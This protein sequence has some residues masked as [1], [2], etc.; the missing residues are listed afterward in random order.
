M[1]REK[2]PRRKSTPKPDSS[3]RQRAAGAQPPPKAWTFLIYL[4]GDNHLETYLDSDFAEICRVGSLP[5]IHVVVQHDRPDGARRYLLPEGPV[6]QPQADANLGRVNTGDPAEAVKFLLW[7]IKQAPS[8]HVA[9]IFNGPGIN[10]NYLAQNLARQDGTETES[11]LAARVTKQL[12]S[13]CHDKTSSD[14]LEAHELRTILEQ[15]TEAEAMNR[16]TIDFIGLDMGA[17]AFV[18][19]A[20]QMEGLAQ[21]LVASQRFVPDNGWPY[22]QIL[23]RWQERLTQKSATAQDLGR[24]IVE[25]VADYYQGDKKYSPDDVRLAAVNLTALEAA[26]RALDT[27]ALALMQSLGDWHVLDA[28]RQAAQPL[29]W[30]KAELSE[31]QTAQATQLAEFLPAV[32]MFELL[33]HVHQALTEKSRSAPEIFGQRERARHLADLAEKALKVLKQGTRSGNRLLLHVR[34]TPDRG[35]SILLP[36]M[37][38]PEQID[39][40]TGPTFDLAGS[41][42]LDLNFS[43][44]VHWAA[45]V[46]AFQLIVEKPHVLWRLISSMLAD[47]SGP[48]RD[49][50]MQRLLSPDS[51]VEGL[52]RQF[53]SLG[54]DRALTLSLDPRDAEPGTERRTYRLRLESTVAGAIV[55]Q[56]ES[57]VYEPSI[58]TALRGLEQ[59][60]NS[61]DDNP[62]VLRDLMAFGRTLGEDLIQDLA[63]RL[64]AERKTA[65]EGAIEVT[66]H[67]RLQIPGELM[68]YPWELMYDRSGMLCERYAMGRQV[69]MATPMA[70]RVMRRRPGP[71]EVLIIGDPEF[72]PEFLEQFEKERRWR[73]PQLRGAEQEARV[74]VE[75]FERLGEELAGLPPLRITRL[76]G[77]TLT[78][79]EFRQRLREGTYD[80]I[81]YAGHACF[82]EKDPEASAWLLSDGLLRAR[83]IRNTLA[84]T[85]SPPWLVFANAC[86]AGMEAGAAASRYQGDVFG[87]ATAFINQGVAA[88]IAPLWLVNDEVAMQMAIDFYRALLLDRLSLGEA[89]RQARVLA[90]QEWASPPRAVASW[91]SLVLYG[92]P[93]PRLL[94][95]LWTPHAERGEKQKREAEKHE[96]RVAPRRRARRLPR[97]TVEQTLR[98]VSGP[99]MQPVSPEP[100]RGEAPV[101][102][103]STELKLVE[104]NGLRYWATV[105]EQGQLKP[106]S[107]LSESL[108]NEKV[109]GMLGAP[110]GV[111]DYAKVVGRWVVGKITGS[112]PESLLLRLVQQYDRETVATEQLL[113]IS[114]D[115]QLT[116][117]PP[118]PAPWDWLTGP[119]DRVLLILHGTFSKT[120][121]P[122]VGLGQEF[123]EWAYKH[124]RGAIGF[125]HWT[126]SKTPEDNAQMLWNRLDPRLRSGHRLDIITHSRGGLVARAFV[127]LLGHGAAVRRVV[128]VGTPNAGTNLANPENWGRVADWLVNLVPADP[129]G[130]YGRLSG[131]LAR[132]LVSDAVGEIPGLQAQNPTATGDQQFLGRLQKPAPLPT[133]VTYAAV[134]ANYEPG[135]AE[136]NL[137][138]VSNQALDGALDQFYGGPNDLV[139]DTASV[140]AVDTTTRSWE[141]TGPLLPA[142]RVLLFNPDP[143]VT[144]PPGVQLERRRGVHHTNL[145]EAEPTR[146]FLQ[147][148]LA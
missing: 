114:P 49:A 133:G 80:I 121:S 81:H 136:V 33:E 28:L 127:E 17:A 69:F 117:L 70:R 113:M 65:T 99:G 118:P 138:S 146:Q 145:F 23:T 86:E 25:T 106:L 51:V 7:G 131:L 134:T 122:V 16:R 19:I 4:C 116:P 14:A 54:E 42:Y 5:D 1:R 6:E 56:Q 128:F 111:L 75:E 71:I 126:L 95:S 87:L 130:L 107:K 102:P 60:L 13:I 100:T 35:L 20:Y 142:Q 88:Y 2:K 46:G 26:G 50:L 103:G 76:I 96:G 137:K 22:D 47:A 148:Q 34:P 63:D 10:P 79:N 91:A 43:Q 125:D 53:Q 140:W 32:D 30:I 38:T 67:L 115:L 135:H 109:R 48:A 58:K 82:E 98:L 119:D 55:A 92:D 57:R 141:Q 36:P 129:T 144:H 73:P 37:R 39:A 101:P 24:L 84:W 108:Q 85:A 147:R 77:A 93:T 78:V 44:H 64:E 72:R 11:E 21:V 123:F 59:L 41:N 31:G 3:R 143:Q 97:A 110:R 120:E 132:L 27:L 89:L 40:E 112:E 105:D 18:E 104:Q 90:K 52:K 62:N 94:E 66:P 61:M 124:Y 83:E 45:L 8:E 15:V 29:H 68:R 139:V 74:V 9:V 12:F